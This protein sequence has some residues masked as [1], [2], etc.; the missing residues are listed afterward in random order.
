MNNH[1]ILRRSLL[2][3]FLLVLAFG[4]LSCS[5]ELAGR[6]RVWIDFPRDG[7]SVSIGETITVTSHAFA[8][9]GIAEVVLSVNGEAYRRDAPAEAGADFTEVAQ[10]W[11]PTEEGFYT[12]QVRVYDTLG[13]SSNPATITVEVGAPLAVL[14]P[15]EAEE[16]EQCAADELVAPALVSPADGATLPP[17]PLLEWSY[18]DGSCHPYSYTIDISEDSSFADI[19]WGFATLNH[20][21]TSRTWPLPAGACYYWRARAYVP[22]THGPES[23]IRTFCIDDS[24]VPVTVTPSLTPSLTLTFFEQVE[25]ATCPPTATALQNSN[26]R[27]GP[28]IAYPVSGSLSE[29]QSSTVVGRNAD[30]S[31]WVIERPGSS[32]TCWVWSDLVQ[33]VPDTCNVKV[34]QAPPLPPTDTPTP[35]IT[36]TITLTTPP[37]PAADTTP[38]PTPAPQKPVNG[39]ELSCSVS[40]TLAWSA[41]SDKSDIAAY[42]VKL[43]K[44]IS[45]GNWQSAGGNTSS[46][47]QIDAPVDCG[48]VYRWMVRAEDG[49]GNFSDWSGSSQFGVKLP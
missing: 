49:A 15:E 35:T 36:P 41:V 48:I 42:Y 32:G 47:T 33:V 27:S 29:G 38:P 37:P 24:T 43:E 17:D 44:Q 21:E 4:A 26:C 20:L 34:H 19:R 31:W 9:E 5:G 28:G 45:A 30:S 40:V 23:K 2:A 11:F 25:E 10:E 22:D 39:A 12:L 14:P 8:R 3:V 16:S 18:P 1:F 46:T 7:A 13:E 6:P